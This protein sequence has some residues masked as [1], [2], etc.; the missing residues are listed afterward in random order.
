[1]FFHAWTTELISIRQD[2]FYLVGWGPSEGKDQGHRNML[3]AMADF[4]YPVRR[5][6]RRSV[7][8]PARHGPSTGLRSS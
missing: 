4:N 6:Q 7:G 8:V 5:H 2:S 3:C 1:V